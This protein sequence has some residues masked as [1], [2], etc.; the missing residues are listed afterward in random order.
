MGSSVDTMT[1]HA[2]NTTGWVKMRIQRT[3]IITYDK[4]VHHADVMDLW[5][6]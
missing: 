1:A 6:L 5:L 4:W 2:N 3:V